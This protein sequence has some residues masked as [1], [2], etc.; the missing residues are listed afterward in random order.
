VPNLRDKNSQYLADH[1]F[2]TM[3][4]VAPSHTRQDLANVAI[5][6]LRAKGVTDPDVFKGVAVSEPHADGSLHLHGCFAANWY[7]SIPAIIELA[8]GADLET[9]GWKVEPDVAY[10]RFKRNSTLGPKIVTLRTQVP[11]TGVKWHL[12]VATAHV[13]APDSKEVK[14]GKKQANHFKSSW[15]FNDMVQYLLCPSKDKIVDPS[16]LFINCDADDILLDETLCQPHTLLDLVR[17]ARL[18]KRDSVPPDEAIEYLVLR[19]GS[20]SKHVQHLQVALK[21]YTLQPPEQDVHFLPDAL[22][23]GAVDAAKP[24]QRWV[25]RFLETS[26]VGEA[27]G[28]WITGPPGYGKTTLMKML[29]VRYPGAVCFA[30][31]RGSNNVYD[32]TALGHYDPK[33]HRI[34]IFNDVKPSGDSAK[35]PETFLQTLRE[36]T[37]GVR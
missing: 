29:Y 10:K 34:L 15:K 22:S 25:C 14:S 7:L 6:A 30:T 5:A 8:R 13:Y 32:R 33:R 1:I 23:T 26:F 16:P 35:W 9:R 2:V 19:S 24:L 20:E 31:L 21:A 36:V 3:D 4:H 18:L 27:N 11:N 17:K 28:L 37:D 12:N